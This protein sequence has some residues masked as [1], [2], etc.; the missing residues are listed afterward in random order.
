MSERGKYEKGRRVSE[1]REKGEVHFLP[2]PVEFASLKLP[3][4]LKNLR[5]SRETAIM[6]PGRRI[7]K[8]TIHDQVRPRELKHAGIISQ[9]GFSAESQR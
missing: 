2:F 7:I 9:H 8:S 1:L 3:A 5:K 6:Y 4:P